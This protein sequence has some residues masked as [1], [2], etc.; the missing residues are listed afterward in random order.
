[1]YNLKQGYIVYKLSKPLGG[2]IVGLG[3]ASTTSKIKNLFERITTYGI[4]K[5]LKPLRL[6]NFA[7]K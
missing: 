6:I 5:Y 7:F 1:M 4:F 2:A 3:G